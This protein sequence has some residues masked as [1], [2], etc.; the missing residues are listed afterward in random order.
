MRR[1]ARLPVLSV[2]LTPL[3]SSCIF[4]PPY[5][6]ENGTFLYDTRI[7]YILKSKEDFAFCSPQLVGCAIPLGSACVV[8]LDQEYFARATKWQQVNLVAHEVG[9]CLDL[10]KLSL[11]HGGFTNEGLRWGEYYGTPSEG[12]AE[13]Y[14]RAYIQKCGLDLD[15]LGWMN[16]RGTCTPPDPRSVTPDFIRQQNL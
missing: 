9:H 13:A 16:A 2:L 3:L 12:F 14:A 15:S 11:S 5:P 6:G 8:Q 1:L 7:T 4:F 10:R